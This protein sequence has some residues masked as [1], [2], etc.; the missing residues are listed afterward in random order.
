MNEAKKMKCF[1]S[2]Y[3]HKSIT[4]NMNSFVSKNIYHSF[5]ILFIKTKKS[6]APIIQ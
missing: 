6:K 5:S 4:F 2:L 3:N 1:S